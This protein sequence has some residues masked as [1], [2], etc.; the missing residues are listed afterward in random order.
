MIANMSSRNSA[1]STFVADR[2][3]VGK[4]CR[5][6]FRSVGLNFTNASSIS[7]LNM[8]SAMEVSRAGIL[9]SLKF[10]SLLRSIGSFAF[11]VDNRVVTAGLLAS[12]VAPVGSTTEAHR[13]LSSASLSNSL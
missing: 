8:P 13:A 5:N 10:S 6:A 9:A 2:S 4:C 7:L 3:L 11:V 12:V 1:S